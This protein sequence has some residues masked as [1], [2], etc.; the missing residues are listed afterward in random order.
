MLPLV[1]ILCLLVPCVLWI[2]ILKPARIGELVLTFFCVLTAHII[3]TGYILSMINHL[4]DISY[5]AIGYGSIATSMIL[6]LLFIRPV[7]SLARLHQVIAQG[8]TQRLSVTQ[9]WNTTSLFERVS[10]TPLLITT[11]LLGLINLCIVIF[12]APH[13]WDSLAYHLPRVSYYLQQNNLNIFDTSYWAQ[14][15]HPKNS[16]LL[17]LYTFLASNRNEHLFQLVQLI[18]YWVSICGVYEIALYL[19]MKKSQA[20]FTA[21]TFALLPTGLLQSTVATND[22]ILTAYTACAISFFLA[23]RKTVHKRYLVLGALSI[24]LAAGVKSSYL[25]ILAPLSLVIVYAIIKRHGTTLKHIIAHMSILLGSLLVGFLLFTLPAGYI[26]NQR[27]FGHPIA[28]DF[29]REQHSFEGKPIEYVITSGTKNMLRFG[30]EFLSL[31]GLPPLSP[32][33]SMQ[34]WIQQPLLQLVHTLGIDLQTTDDIKI[35]GTFRYN[36]PPHITENLSYWGVFG[37]GLIWIVV[38]W[39]IFK[40]TIHPG[41]RILATASILFVLLQAYSGPYDQIRGRYFL[42]CAVFATPSLGICLRSKNKMIQTY[43]ITI[44]LAGCLTS[45][46]AVILRKDSYPF[47][48]TYQETHKPS[49]FQLNR[50]QQV[51]RLRPDYYD[52]MY[53]YDQLVPDNATVAIYL[54]GFSYEYPL[55]GETL[56]RNIVPINPF[57][58]SLQPIPKDADYL[59]Y[60]KGHAISVETSDISLGKE[61]YIRK[62]Q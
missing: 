39:A 34:S 55:M 19:E 42:A 32:I 61:W 9:W 10:I 15:I 40:R 49:V 54:P 20:L 16:T 22:M 62:L 4:S 21:L 44:V 13:N 43:I 2:S 12:T 45:A 17:F 35:G 53:T 58:K 56:E 23:F 11:A 46:S 50:L 60:I 59:L 18:A 28:P 1:S 24:S 26:D 51:T 37:F 6:L 27:T 14:I 30:F 8:L 47:S 5:W 38:I 52:I 57:W 41:I 36:D 48:F 3:V 25:L 29:I 33:R 31:D 7:S